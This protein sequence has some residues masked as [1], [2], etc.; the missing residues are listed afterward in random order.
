LR[1][2]YG[3]RRKLT[4]AERSE[5]S[6]QRNRDHAQA[7]RQRRK[8]FKAILAIKHTLDDGSA[9]R[10]IQDWKGAGNKRRKL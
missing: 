2:K 1:G 4:I 6:R 8:V 9:D 7:T 10:L 3:K 5:V